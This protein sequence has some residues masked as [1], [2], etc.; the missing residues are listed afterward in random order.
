MSDIL[1]PNVPDL[2]GSA[3]AAGQLR[4]YIARAT[5]N[6]VRAERNL[7]D[8][9]KT[10]DDEGVG[11]GLEI[12]DVLSDPLRARTDGVIV[13]PTLIGL[14]P[15]GR[16]TMLGD[17]VDTEQ[18]KRLL[19]S[20]RDDQP[21]AIM[22]RGQAADNDELLAE[23]A[24]MAEE[25]KHRMRNNLQLVHAM[26]GRHLKIVSEANERASINEIIRRVATLATVYDELLGSGMGRTVDL[27]KYVTSLCENL[28]GLQSELAE[29][30]KLTCTAKSLI[31]DLDTVTVL[32]MVVA[33]VVSNSY[34]HAFPGGFGSI[35]VGLRR[36][37]SGDEAIL[38]VDDNGPGF[39]ERPGTTRHGLGLVRRLMEQVD[40]SAELRS[41]RGTGWTFRFPVTAYDASAES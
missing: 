17:L 31:V 20:L 1:A 36:S 33:E 32:G 6:S 22:G 16:V 12:V 34:K 30:V 26:L 10:L 14:R 27:G 40:G 39:I 15:N 19:Q 3:G 2:G 37:V 23:N 28:P 18:L 4:L 24:V 38:T 35:D 21:I 7:M 5:L 29:G 11:W 13:T 9:L 41:E 25:L 8:T